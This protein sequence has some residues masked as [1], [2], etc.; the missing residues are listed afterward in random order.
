MHLASIVVLT[1]ASPALAGVRGAQDDVA[2]PA[3]PAARR[4]QPHG[5]RGDRRRRHWAAAASP[6]VNATQSPSW[7][8]RD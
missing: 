6:T 4:P 5:G 3:V 1:L 8:L 7:T 2:G